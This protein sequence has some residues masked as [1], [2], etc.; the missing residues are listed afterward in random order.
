MAQNFGKEELKMEKTKPNGK[1]T[2]YLPTIY[3]D[4]DT[5]E[6]LTKDFKIKYNYQ[7]INTEKTKFYENKKFKQNTIRLVKIK[8]K[9]EQQLDLF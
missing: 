2:I 7:F 1:N 6:E 8:S 9:I 3:V 5:G 4:I